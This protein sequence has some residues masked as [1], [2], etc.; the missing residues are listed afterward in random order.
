MQRISTN[1]AAGSQCLQSSGRSSFALRRFFRATVLGSAA[2]LLGC[3][4]ADRTDQRGFKTPEEGAAALVASLESGN[5]EEL[6]AILG[7]EG[8]E[9]ISSG[10]PVSDQAEKKKFVERFREQSRIERLSDEAAFVHVGSQ[11]WPMPIPLVK[12]DGEWI[13]DTESGKEVIIDRRIGKNELN[14]IQVC[15]A[16]ADAQEE[17]WREDRDGD[18]ILEYSQKFRSE[19]GKRDGL[20]WPTAEGEPPS[21]LGVLAAEAA[22]EGYRASKDAGR[23]TPFHGY[24]YRILTAQGPQAK[25]GA[26]D[27]VVNGSMVGG[28]ALIAI[29]AEYGASGIM[30]F[31]VN[32]EGTVYEKDL[33]EKAPSE[34]AE[35]K[36]FDPDKTWSPVS[37]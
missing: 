30:S 21:P 26:Y 23:S 33:G 22:E 11:D 15:L 19:P 13:F 7:P 10:D 36:T 8:D 2:F 1:H 4:G 5:I 25:S 9:I 29:P 3:A 37:Q 24:F 32:H 16:Y 35:I 34:A 27:Y 17:Y 31:L 6:K 18:G 28:F 12:F 20:Y 14:A